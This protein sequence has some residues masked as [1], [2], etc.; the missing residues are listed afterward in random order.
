MSQKAKRTRGFLCSVSSFPQPAEAS[1][2]PSPQ[3]EISPQTCISRGLRSI[4]PILC[5]QPSISGSS[6]GKCSRESLLRHAKP[7]TQPALFYSILCVS[8]RGLHSDSFVPATIPAAS[9][10]AWHSLLHG[11]LPTEQLQGCPAAHP[12]VPDRHHTNQT[13]QPQLE[14]TAALSLF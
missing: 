13:Q 12:H 8:P 10:P 9:S 3:L 6:M 7:E 2:M 4:L 5:H 14:L 11:P 1:Q